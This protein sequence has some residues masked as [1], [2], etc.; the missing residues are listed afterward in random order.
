MTSLDEV[1]PARRTRRQIANCK[2]PIANL[3][4]AFCNDQFAMIFGGQ[5]DGVPAAAR[6]RS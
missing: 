5:A 1:V 6:R 3:K 2:L 4:F